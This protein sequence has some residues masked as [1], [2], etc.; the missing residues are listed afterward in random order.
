MKKVTIQGL[1]SESLIKSLIEVCEQLGASVDVDELPD[2][3][4]ESCSVEQA[5]TRALIK[6]LK[7]RGERGNVPAM[8]EHCEVM[9]EHLPLDVLVASS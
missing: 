6:V 8:V 2:H 4:I 5:S 1:K 3:P 9:L 7:A